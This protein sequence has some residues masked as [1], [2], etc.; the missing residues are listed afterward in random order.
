MWAPL[1]KHTRPIAA[2][3]ASSSKP[4]ISLPSSLSKVQVKENATRITQAI[5]DGK[6]SNYW[7]VSY[8]DYHRTKKL[9]GALCAMS[10]EHEN[11]CWLAN[12]LL[13]ALRNLCLIK[14]PPQVWHNQRR[15]NTLRATIQGIKG[16]WL[17]LYWN[18]RHAIREKLQVALPEL[19]LKV[20]SLSVSVTKT[21]LGW[22][23]LPELFLK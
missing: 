3:S 14:R 7:L 23:N 20:C 8:K 5:P 2:P 16:Y 11:W 4:S 1:S 18:R 9:R 13:C 21:T 19:W 6:P 12:M 15:Y 22:W 17:V 10:P